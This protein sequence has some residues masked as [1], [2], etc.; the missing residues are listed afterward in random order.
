MIKILWVSR[1]K[2][3]REQVEELEQAFGKVEITRYCDIVY[4][5]AQLM[6]VYDDG[7]YDEMVV[8][9]PV[10]LIRQLVIMG[11]KPLKPV[12]HREVIGFGEVRLQHHHFERILYID[13]VSEPLMGE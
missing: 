1:H 6:E 12:L 9:L 10:Q 13:Y 4:N 7:E 8:V 5:V 11:V 2:P 3:L